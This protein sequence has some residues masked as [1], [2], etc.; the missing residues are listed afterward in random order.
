VRWG[1]FDLSHY[2]FQDAV[3]IFD[4]VPIREPDHAIALSRQ[5]RGARRIG[6]FPVGMLAAVELNH[7]L[8]RRAGEIGDAP[9]DGMLP[10]ELPR[11]APLPQ[12]A[13]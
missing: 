3:N 8:S 2:G 7:Q 1:T 11:R 9:A 4:N 5:L 12:R 13:P 10:T 6:I